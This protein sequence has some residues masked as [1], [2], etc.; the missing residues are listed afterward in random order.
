M[1]DTPFSLQSLSPAMMRRQQLKS[2]TDLYRYMPSVQGDGARPQTRGM[3]GSVVQNSMIDGLNVVSTTDYAAEQFDHIRVDHIEVLNGLAGSLYAG[4]PGWPF[5]LRGEVRHRSAAASPYR[6]QQQRQPQG[7]RR[8]QRV[9]R[10]GRSPA[11]PAES[12]G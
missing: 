9:A 6:R 8:F 3:Q 5:Q 11:L 1:R 10:S 7:R 2:V 12:A 4:Q